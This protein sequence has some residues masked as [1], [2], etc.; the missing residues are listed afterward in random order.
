MYV[1]QPR[2]QAL[3]PCQHPVILS[4]FCV[5]HL[6]TGKEKDQNHNE[7]DYA[8]LFRQ[9]FSELLRQ[10]E[11]DPSV[12]G[13]LFTGFVFPLISFAQYTFCKPVSFNKATFSSNANFRRTTFEKRAEFF[14]TKFLGMATFSDAT[15]KKEALF[16]E[17]F[18]K[19]GAH[20]TGTTF[21]NERPLFTE[22]TFG[23]R[24]SFKYAIF[25]KGVKYQKAKFEKPVSFNSATIDEDTVFE[26]DTNKECFYAESEFC[27]LRLRKDANLFFDHVSLARATFADTNVESFNFRGVKWYTPQT[28]PRRKRALWDE[29]KP[30]V[31][32]GTYP[33][34][35]ENYSQLVKNHEDNRDYEAAEDFHIG[36]MEI[37]RKGIEAEA[38]RH[39]WKK[40][41]CL[42][43]LYEAYRFLS[44]YGTSYG[45]ASIVLLVLILSCAWMFLFTGLRQA[46]AD[47]LLNTI[48]SARHLAFL[49][50]CG[51]VI[52]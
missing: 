22:V 36:E 15:F 16:W 1:S 17:T 10:I 40:H 46:T 48:S 30:Q 4:G 47:R 45:Q 33:H 44:N 42:L 7:G 23:G 18:F 24:S 3:Y 31:S 29:F 37:R 11:G 32:E 38:S 25:N 21:E 50:L 49:R 34:V 51:C 20:F 5:F 9:M 13:Y 12:P 43:N 2:C 39:K 6:P 8:A 26:G 28:W 41:L 19:E 52:I 14:G 35:A 27:G